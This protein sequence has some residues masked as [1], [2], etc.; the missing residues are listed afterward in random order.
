MNERTQDRLFAASGI[1]SVL[2]MLAGVAIGATGGREFA[3]IS[4]TPA[5]IAHALAKPAGPAVWVGAYLELLSFGCFLAFA[6]WACAKLGGGLLGAIGR[7]TATS[8][9]TVSIVA[10]AVGDAIEYRAG[11]GVGVQLGSALITVNEALFVG[12][13]FLAVFFL[14]AVGPLALMSDRRGLGWSAIGTAATI[15]VLTA[16]SLDN[17]GQ[18]SNVLWLI[19]I[20]GASIA[21]GRGERAPRGSVAVAQR[22]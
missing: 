9:A 8:Y 2:V 14:L 1:A 15:L 10:L 21:L 12:T 20:V 13:W 3:T 19:W 11:H 7:A 6:V 22:T 17:L 4:S 5:Q 18:L 16:V